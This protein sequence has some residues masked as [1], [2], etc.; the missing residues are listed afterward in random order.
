[1]KESL[2]SGF[3]DQDKVLNAALPSRTLSFR[4]ASASRYCK[5][6]DCDS[7]KGFEQLCDY[8]REEKLSHEM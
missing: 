7:E 2:R 6:Y 3:D 1:M 4:K 8:F 5:P